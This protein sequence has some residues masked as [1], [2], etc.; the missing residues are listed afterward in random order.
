MAWME[1]YGVV[2][3]AVFSAFWDGIVSQVRAVWEPYSLAMMIA[4]G[5]GLTRAYLVLFVAAKSIVQV[6]NKRPYSKVIGLKSHARSTNTKGTRGQ[7][8]AHR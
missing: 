6:Y 4:G 5:K 8:K 7:C 2:D 1:F 3:F